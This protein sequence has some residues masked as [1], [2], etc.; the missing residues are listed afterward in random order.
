MPTPKITN[1]F[2]LVFGLALIAATAGVS[3][4]AGPDAPDTLPNAISPANLDCSNA[5]KPKIVEFELAGTASRAN[6]LAHG[7]CTKAVLEESL[8]RD[9]VFILSYVATVAWFCAWG[10]RRF[11]STKLRTLGWVAIGITVV[12]AGLDVLENAL[13]ENVLN[14]NVNSARYAT[15]ASLAKWALLV[16]PITYAFGALVTLAVR[17]FAKGPDPHPHGSDDP[18]KLTVEAPDRLRAVRGRTSLALAYRHWW[19]SRPPT[20]DAWDQPS[21]RD[22]D[23]LG[24]AFSGGGIRSASFHLGV[25]ERCIATQYPRTTG[26]TRLSLLE[27]ARYI[28]TVSGGG[29]VG[30]ARQIT[31]HQANTPHPAPLTARN[32]FAEGSPEQSFVVNRREY[33]WDTI[34]LCFVGVAKV[35]LGIAINLALFAMLLYVAARPIGWFAGSYIFEPNLVHPANEAGFWVVAAGLGALALVGY[36]ARGLESV[37]GRCAR[38]VATCCGSASGVLVL[39]GLVTISTRWSTIIVVG[40]TLVVAVVGGFSAAPAGKKWVLKGFLFTGVGAGLAA[41]AVLVARFWSR[42]GALHRVGG[43]ADL[44]VRHLQVLV[45]VAVVY[46]V[47]IPLIY[48]LVQRCPWRLWPG[49]GCAVVGVVV[50]VFAWWGAGRLPW[51]LTVP[52]LGFWGGCVVVLAV[53]LLFVDQRLWSPHVFY[54]KRLLH[55]FSPIRND[56]NDDSTDDVQLSMDVTTDL[57]DWAARVPGQPE[58]LVCAAVHLPG[59]TFGHRP[60]G[61]FTFSQ[62]QVGGPDVGWVATS[63]FRASLR[64]RV[65]KDGT[66]G[67]ALAISGAAIAAANGYM[68][69]GGANAALALLNARLGVWLPNPTHVHELEGRRP[70]QEGGGGVWIGHRNIGYSLKE[71]FGNYDPLDRFVYVSDG[72]HHDNL[73]LIELLR[74]RCKVILC[75]DASGDAKGTVNTFVE[76]RER[77]RCELGVNITPH[78]P[79][80]DDD[81]RHGEARVAAYQIEYPYLEPPSGVDEHPLAK[82]HGWLVFAKC[83]TVRSGGEIFPCTDEETGKFPR[84]TTAHQ[85]FSEVRLLAYRNLGAKVADEALER[86]DQMIAARLVDA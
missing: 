8:R 80:E 2:W 58:L 49:V 85:W 37:V 13:L 54:K 3:V 41:L 20:P 72:G 77:A 84:D 79:A 42:G 32:A 76:I 17:W 29:Y 21:P 71:V 61:S 55:T 14:G 70:P 39:V 81:L 65:A 25:L 53:V 59:T 68:N 40:A 44:G 60:V 35:F 6:D 24:I 11:R 30:T 19:A 28:A 33:L 9:S 52:E 26:E 18:W 36:V 31:L 1:I 38:A 50:A 82:Q 64:N 66:L 47:A 12:A 45:L 73:G 63:E 22:N 57:D 67:A 34:G 46:I 43:D 10:A 83:T 56:P 51:A 16:V 23:V 4:W 62:T 78:Y 69:L 74:R 5:P 75:F 48:F 86:L 7:A 15:A 27:R